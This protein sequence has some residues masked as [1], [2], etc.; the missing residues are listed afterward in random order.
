MVRQI[1]GAVAQFSKDELV[2]KLA[3][4]RERKREVNKGKG[5]K[6]V[7]GAGKCE[8]RKSIREKHPEL[9]GIVRSLYRKNRTTGKRR[10]F[11]EI[12]RKLL[13]MGYGNGNGGFMG[14]EVV[15]FLLR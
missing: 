7:S 14:T 1:L 3:N 2:A 6:T 13:E 12:S 5:I 4:A 9:G 8:G 15:R 10:S 11:R